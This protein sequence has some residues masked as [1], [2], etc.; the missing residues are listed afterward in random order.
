M[1][2]SDQRSPLTKSECAERSSYSRTESIEEEDE[3]LLHDFNDEGGINTTST[4]TQNQRTRRFS[5]GLKQW[6]IFNVTF[7]ILNL[8]VL[9]F[10]VFVHKSGPIAQHVTETLLPPSPAIEAIEKELRPFSLTSVY[11]N[12]PGPETD[13]LWEELVSSGAVFL[14]S[15]E[16]FL[17]VND[18]PETGIKYAHDPQDRYLGMLAAH[19]QIHCVDALR[20]A[21]WFNY[22]HYKNMGDSL[23]TEKEPPEHHLMHCVEMLRNAVMCHGDVSIISYNWK[24]GYDSPK[25]NF[26]SLHVCQKWDKLEAWRETHNVTSQI[27]TL[28]RPVGFF[29]GH[30]NDENADY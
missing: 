20:K 23:F 4:E 16:E 8:A 24:K 9:L 12:Y 21:M 25:G 5:L 29:D 10:L 22:E 7:T 15:K 19:H 17:L 13:R 3:S 11:D 18:N 28:E 2:L 26:K 1:D 6:V 14:L 30:Q 27:K